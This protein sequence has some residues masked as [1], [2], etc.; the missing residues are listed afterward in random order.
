MATIEEQVIPKKIHGLEDLYKEAETNP[1]WIL[2][3]CPVYEVQQRCF[4]ALDAQRRSGCKLGPSDVQWAEKV[5]HAACKQHQS[6]RYEPILSW[7]LFSDKVHPDY[8]L[9]ALQFTLSLCPEQFGSGHI[10]KLVAGKL[11]GPNREGMP[12]LYWRCAEI[13]PFLK[14]VLNRIMPRETA[15]PPFRYME[16]SWSAAE[17]ALLLITLHMDTR[18]AVTVHDLVTSHLDGSTGLDKFSHQSPFTHPHIMTV[19]R[20]TKRHLTKPSF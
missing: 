8:D 4:S 5:M 10:S 14:L 15:S 17:R 6:A 13:E 7:Y 11:K 9:Q 16:N 20:E 19:L 2:M 12:E 3:T 18:F 1:R